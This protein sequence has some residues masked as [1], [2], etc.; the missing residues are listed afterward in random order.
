MRHNSKIVDTEEI[1]VPNRSSK[2]DPS[3]GMLS[4]VKRQQ[5][6]VPLAYVDHV[7]S[8]KLRKLQNETKMAKKAIRMMHNRMIDSQTS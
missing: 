3:S 6:M 1:K 2:I 4:K 7:Y 5:T 8:E